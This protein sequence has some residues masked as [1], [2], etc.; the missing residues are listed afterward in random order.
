MSSLSESSRLRDLAGGLTPV[1]VKLL[2]L[3]IALSVAVSG[4]AVVYHLALTDPTV[5]EGISLIAFLSIP[6]LIGLAKVAHGMWG[7]ERWAWSW[8]VAYFGFF[9]LANLVLDRY[10][11]FA[12]MLGA[13]IYLSDRRYVFEK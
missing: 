1:G 4:I 8:G 3:W 6:V 10:F 11:F 12:V 9:A 2:S 7:L 13:L 5:D